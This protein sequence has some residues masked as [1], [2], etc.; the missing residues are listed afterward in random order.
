MGRALVEPWDEQLIS[1]A[2]PLLVLLPGP[3]QS[4]AWQD[5]WKLLQGVVL[6]LVFCHFISQ[7]ALSPCPWQLISKEEYNNHNVVFYR[8]WAFNPST[9]NPFSDVH[10]TTNSTCVEMV[11]NVQI[12]TAL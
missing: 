7:A 2:A 3:S 9:S 1:G 6:A 11:T 5:S 10:Y 12:S 4:R 8:R